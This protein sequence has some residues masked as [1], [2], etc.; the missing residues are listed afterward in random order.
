LEKDFGN[1]LFSPLVPKA[2]PKQTK[3]E[4]VLCR[5]ETTTFSPLVL[6]SRPK[7]EKVLYRGQ[8]Q[9]FSPLVTKKQTKPW[10][11]KREKALNRGRDHDFL[12]FGLTKATK[13]KKVLNFLF[14]LSILKCHY[15]ETLA[16]ATD[17]F[18]CLSTRFSYIILSL[19]RQMN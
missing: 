6:P 8:D 10:W 3:E 16:T 11:T 1:Q 19:Q 14:P 15:L 18:T 2:A 12:S 13:G 7:E 9:L 17:Y 5:G 4:K